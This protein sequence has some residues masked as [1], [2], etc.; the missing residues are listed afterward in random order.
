MC[1]T[2][3]RQRNEGSRCCAHANGDTCKHKHL[4]ACL[5][6]SVCA[7]AVL[8]C[9]PVQ[10]IGQVEAGLSA[11]APV[12]GDRLEEAAGQLTQAGQEAAQQIKVGEPGV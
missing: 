2:W 1:G 3:Q 12:V 7:A 6:L 4:T 5:P 11:A 8:C 9:C 10:A